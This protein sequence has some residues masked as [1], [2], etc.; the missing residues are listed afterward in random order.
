MD[1]PVIPSSQFIL[2]PR[3]RRR[4]RVADSPFPAVFERIMRE[5]NRRLYRLALGIIG[6]ASAAE[7]VL[8]DAYVKAF[9]NF[10]KLIELPRLGAWLARI[11]RNVAVD[12][13]RARKSRQAA[14]A[15]ESELFAPGG[16][17]ASLLERSSGRSRDGDPVASLSSDELRQRLEAAIASLPA[18]FRAVFLLREVEG[19]SLQ[20]SASYLGVPVATI[21]TRDHRAR[22]LLREALGGEFGFPPAESFDFGRERC[23]RLV[24]RVLARLCPA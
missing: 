6:D 15:F 23:D 2:P 13:C 4:A 12:H 11:V 14:Y 9:R 17:G 20:Q 22:L 7:D 19:L 5:H 21:K 3:G 1:Y 16:D 18:P 24:A 8:Q 10:P